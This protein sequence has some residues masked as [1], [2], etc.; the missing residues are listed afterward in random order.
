MLNAGV[1]LTGFVSGF[2]DALS[3]EDYWPFYLSS[4]VL[5]RVWMVCIAFT[6]T[7][8]SAFFNRISVFI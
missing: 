4:L 1:K 2:E 7:K 6:G 5:S 8:Q 3:W